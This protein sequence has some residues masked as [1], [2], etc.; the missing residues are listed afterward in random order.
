MSFRVGGTLRSVS[1]IQANMGE[2]T[3]KGKSSQMRCHVVTYI[4]SS[5]PKT[6]AACFSVVPVDIY[7]IKQRHIPEDNNLL[8]YH[9]D[10]LT[11]HFY[12]IFQ[13]VLQKEE[14]V[15]HIFRRY[16]CISMLTPMTCIIPVEHFSFV[17]V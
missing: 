17:A 5:T 6:E 15:L 3:K 10:N 9:R 13:N 2:E 14:M 4:F 1:I 12:I 11:S 16:A 8:S 7:Q